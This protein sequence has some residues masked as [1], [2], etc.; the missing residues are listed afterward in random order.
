MDRWTIDY[1]KK[2]QDGWIV[3]PEDLKY[4]ISKHAIFNVYYL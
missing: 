4:L 1:L 3:N 2:H